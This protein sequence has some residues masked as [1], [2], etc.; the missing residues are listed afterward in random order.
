MSIRVEESLAVH[1]RALQVRTQRSEI[2]AANLANQDTPGFL[3]RDIDFAG[4]MR[5]LDPQA[6]DA[7]LAFADDDAQLKYRIPNQPSE[8]GNTVEQGVEQS[9]FARNAMGF[10]TSLTF[11]GMKFRGLKQ[12]IEGR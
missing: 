3:A 6:E 10:Q 7:G 11:L 8:D 1:V 5:R 4:E 9:E 12:A 2:L